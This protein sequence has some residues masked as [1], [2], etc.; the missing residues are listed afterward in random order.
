MGNKNSI[1]ARLERRINVAQRAVAHHPAVRLYDLE[2]LHHAVVGARLLF[3]YD[4]NRV[5]VRLQARAF[6]LG[7]WLGRLALGKKNES[8]MLRKIR[9]RLW[10]AIEDQRRS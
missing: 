5:E 7:G 8:V 6:H 10:H 2:L 3:Q 9:E 1:Q 4:F